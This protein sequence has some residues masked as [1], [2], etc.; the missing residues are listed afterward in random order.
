MK[1]VILAAGIGSR[2]RPMTNT[3]PKCLVTTAGLPILQYQI[4]AYQAAGISEIVLV[5][6]YEGDALRDYCK[7]L[8]G[9]TIHIVENP[10]YETTNNM[11]SLFLTKDIVGDSA[12][13]LNNADLSIDPS[14]VSD[15]LNCAAEDAIAVDTSLYND[16]SMKVS[17]NSAGRITNISKGIPESESFACSIDFYKFSAKASQVFFSEMHRIIEV[18]QN[19]KDWTEVAMQ[20]LMQ[21]GRLE[22]E[23]CDISGKL[24]VEIDDYADLALSDRVFSGLY[25]KIADIDNVLLD[26]DG[27]LYVGDRAVANASLAIDDLRRL[28]KKIYFFSNNSSKI[29]A[30]IV[31][32]LETLGIQASDS[33][34]V[35]S[36]D[37]LIEYLKK[38]KV[39]NI[40]VLGTNAFKKVLLDEGFCIDSDKP[41]YVVLGYDTELTYQKLCTACRYLNEGV[42]MIATHCD[43]FCPTEHGPVPD[44]GSMIEMLKVTTGKSPVKVFGK[45]NAE[46]VEPLISAYSIDPKRTMIVGDRLH[47]DIRMASNFNCYGML[48][49]T[50]D[51]SRDQVE[52]AEDRPDFVINSIGDL[53]GI[54][55]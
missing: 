31:T 41:E 39:E 27:T 30:E 12:F 16:E 42:D 36:T 15:L 43:N 10:D 44:I 54:G 14:I 38:E 17:V 9:I 7:H 53:V 26:L 3:K 4:D 47:T 22:F 8:K 20:R 24:W 13:M 45:P 33:Q 21:A 6:G 48:V 25:S 52:G 46:M 32:K 2:L 49:L 1:G 51:T 40:H 23:P 29:K 50:G 18:E 35:L 19:L 37:G 34:I 5:V 28:G 55:R 11:Y